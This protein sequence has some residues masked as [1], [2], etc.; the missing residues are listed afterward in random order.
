MKTTAQ[1]ASPWEEGEIGYPNVKITVSDRR[2]E[3]YA[4]MR[5]LDGAST[6]HRVRKCRR[7]P[8]AQA[9]TAAY[10]AQ[11]QRAHYSG[12]QTC[13][14]VW[15]CPMCAEKIAAGRRSDLIAA[16]E[17]ADA[18][19]LV[20]WMVTT[21]VQHHIG[22]RLADLMTAATRCGR[23]ASQRRDVRDL[24]DASGIVGVIKRREET[25]GENGWHP[26]THELVFAPPGG[27]V[28]AW[29]EARHAGYDAALQK[30]YSL[31]SMAR[32]GGLDI[33]ALNLEEARQEVAAY[34]GKLEKTETTRAAG[35]LTAGAWQKNARQR[36]SCTSWQLLRDAASGDD[37]AAKLWA[38]YERATKGRRQLV[39]SPGLRGLLGL[40]GV[41]LTD[42]ELAD[43][44]DQDQEDVAIILAADWPT[45]YADQQAL[46]DLLEVCET[47]APGLRFQAMQ[48]YLDA[49]EIP[50]QLHRPGSL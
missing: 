50:V 41:E 43:E 25:H 20:V 38:E 10:R 28:R 36:T 1:G 16:V 14:S 13:G 32:S 7:V 31:R 30:H 8:T 33:R 45:I 9:V 35:E 21:T 12:L 23:L 19:G 34:M 44:N 37:Q 2:R 22:Q 4:L 17:A 11:D 3:A 26:H 18:M 29:A 5:W 39:W 42:D 15:A 40:E 24:R 46:S 6:L 27:D 47:S 48:A 49:R